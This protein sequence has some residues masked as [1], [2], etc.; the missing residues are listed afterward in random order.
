MMTNH[1]VIPDNESRKYHKGIRSKTMTNGRNY[2]QPTSYLIRIQGTIDPTWSDWFGGFTITLQNGE[3]LLQGE[4]R[5]QAALHGILAK[6]NDLGLT[7]VF[8]ERIT[9]SQ[10]EEKLGALCGSRV[11]IRRPSYQNRSKE[12]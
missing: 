2:D 8:V 3:T 6:I 9:Q 5:D 1:L 4:V 11:K 10:K 7:I 12:T